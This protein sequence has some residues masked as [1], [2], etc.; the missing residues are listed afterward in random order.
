MRQ[1][2]NSAIGQQYE[3]I[4]TR[5]MTLDKRHITG[6]ILAGGR[7]TRMGHADKGLQA[8]GGKP[9]VAQVIERFAP[10][11]GTLMINA[12]RN[13]ARYREFGFPV[14]PDQVDGYAGPLAGLHAG[15]VQCATDYL[16]MTPCDSPFVPKDLVACLADALVTTNADLAYAMTGTMPHRQPHPVFCLLKASL[17]PQLTVYLQS[18]GRKMQA[19]YETFNAV[20]VHFPNEQSFIN[21]N[22]VAELDRYGIK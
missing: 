18:G 11:V 20:G 14:H 19:W 1:L 12:N 7:G 13:V 16:A 15:L 10:Q 5:P 4:Y 6:L 8:L 17:L 2:R 3:S 21:I 9:M 22:T